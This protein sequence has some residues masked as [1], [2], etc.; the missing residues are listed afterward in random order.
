[1]SLVISLK[2]N[3]WKIILA[4]LTNPTWSFLCIILNTALWKSHHNFY[5]RLRSGFFTKCFSCWTNVYTFVSRTLWYPEELF[6]HLIGGV[7]SVGVK[8]SFMRHWLL[9]VPG[10]GLF[11]EFSL[12]IFCLY[13]LLL[14]FLPWWCCVLPWWCKRVR[15][16]SVANANVKTQHTWTSRPK[17]SFVPAVP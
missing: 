14:Q 2:L 6:V 12:C 9:T 1:M 8:G 11:Q 17:N 5:I 7:L 4:I 3:Q 10:S 16:T 15:V 13:I